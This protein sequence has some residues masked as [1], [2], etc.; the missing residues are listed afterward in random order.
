[1][2][3]FGIADNVRNFLE[4]SMEQWIGPKIKIKWEK[5]ITAINAWAVAVFRYGAGVLQ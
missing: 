1:M 4:K 5:Q 3:L 2:K